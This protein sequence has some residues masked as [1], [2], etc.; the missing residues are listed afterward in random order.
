MTQ[1]VLS[2]R[3]E[4]F[5]SMLQLSLIDGRMDEKE[6]ELLEAS[7]QEWNLNLNKLQKLHDQGYQAHFEPESFAEK[8]DALAEFVMLM[9]IDGEIHPREYELCAS[10]AH[11]LSLSNKDLDHIIQL[12]RNLWTL[13][14]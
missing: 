8:E 7:A 9:L 3:E 1:P 11:L 12:T 5:L 4:L 10:F 6:R 2:P 14:K 13:G